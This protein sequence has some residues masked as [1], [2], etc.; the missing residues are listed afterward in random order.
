[1]LSVEE[2][3]RWAPIV[4]SDD[5]GHRS[6]PRHGLRL[7]PDP[8]GAQPPAGGHLSGGQQQMLAIGRGLMA[9]PKILL[10]DEPSPRPVADPGAGDLHHH[11]PAQS[12]AGRDDDAGR[13]E[14]QGGAGTCRLRLCA[15]KSA[16][17]S[18]PDRPPSLLHP[19]TSRNSISGSRARPNAARNA[20]NGGRPG[21]ENGSA[22]GR[23][24]HERP[25]EDRGNRVKGRP[26][27]GPILLDG[28]D[29][30]AKL[31]P[32]PA[33]GAMARAWRIGRRTWASGYPIAGPNIYERARLDRPGSGGAWPE[34]RRC[35][36]D[37]VGRQQGMALLR[38]GRDVQWA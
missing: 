28:C 15:W 7:F 8:E 12:R 31:F 37:P 35:R 23:D 34:A 3:L 16:A 24:R 9:R 36:L 29:T 20:G 18:W 27:Q 22:R 19:K 38:H 21:A 26:D 10:L 25:A 2:N 13:T 11:P 33:A 17:S 6:R 1:M 5:G 32:P 30:M 4:R 14:R